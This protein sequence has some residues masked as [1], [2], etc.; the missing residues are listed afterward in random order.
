MSNNSN[1]EDFLSFLT[2]Y[3]SK[4]LELEELRSKYIDR[5]LAGF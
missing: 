4:M 5:N 1:L 2:S 3:P